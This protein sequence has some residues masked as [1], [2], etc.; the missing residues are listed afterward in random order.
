MQR[1]KTSIFWTISCPTSKRPV[2]AACTHS[3]SRAHG[4]RSMRCSAPDSCLMM[5]GSPSPLPVHHVTVIR[6]AARQGY[7]VKGSGFD[8]LAHYWLD[9]DGSGVL[10]CEDVERE[11]EYGGLPMRLLV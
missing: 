10:E 3:M 11:G 6:D 9:H 8:F 7:S 4:K 1:L 5:P 2:N